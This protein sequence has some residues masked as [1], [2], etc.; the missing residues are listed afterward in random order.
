MKRCEAMCEEGLIRYIPKIDQSQLSIQS[1]DE[2]LT[3]E[4]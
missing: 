1:Y 4:R 3:N 2:Q